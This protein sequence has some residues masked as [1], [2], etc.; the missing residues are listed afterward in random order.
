[1]KTA[2]TLPGIWF[3]LCCALTVSGAEISG[4]IQFIRAPG[5]SASTAIIYAETVGD[6]APVKPGRYQMTQH[7]KTFSP[8]VLAVPVGSTVSFPNADPIFHNVFSMSSP[9]PFDLGLYRAGM[10]KTL[11][12][13]E[14]AI[15]RIFCNIHPQ[16]MAQLLVLPTQ[17]ITESDAQGTYRMDLPPGRYRLTAW[18]E[19]SS[20]ITVPIALESDRVTV[21]NITLDESHFVE[22]LH[23]NKYGQDY[24]SNSYAPLRR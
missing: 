13:T 5:Q 7:N 24:P 12:F 10:S 18:S 15:Y 20:P 16:M 23:K 17:W 6:H 4:H 3:V 22:V 2:Q 1:M 19:R 9:V 11:V 21:P 14:P 8:H